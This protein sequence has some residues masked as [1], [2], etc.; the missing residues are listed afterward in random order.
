MNSVFI[1]CGAGFSGDR[2]DAASPVISSLGSVNGPRYLIYEVLAERTLAIA[3]KTRRSFPNKG[4]S[5]YLERYLAPILGEVMA[6]GIKIVTN[7][8]AANPLEA[9]R[10]VKK[11][12][13]DKNIE[14]LRIAIVNGDD[15]L[16]I[17]SEQYIRSQPII[18]GVRIGDEEIIAA[19]A[20]LGAAPIAEAL[21]LGVNIVL[22]GRTTDAALTLGPLIHE[23][24]WS[25]DD[26]DRLAQGTLAGHFLECGAQITGAYFADP[27]F[28]N[29]KGLE[30]VGFPI[31]E[32]SEIGDI[33]I[34]KANNTGGLVDRKT[35]IE[36][37]LYEIHD[38][39]NYLSA[40]VTLDLSRVSVEDV[41]KDR[42]LVSGAKGSSPPLTLKATISIDGGWISE[43]EITYAGPNSLARAEMAASIIRKR[44]QIIG[45]Q[46]IVRVDIFGT[47]SV[48]DNDNSKRRKK[49]NF[50]SYGEYRVRAAVRSGNRDICQ[51]VSDEVLSLYCS[52]PA[53]GGGV[54]QFID[55]QV[56][57]ASILVE[58]EEVM[59][60]VEVLEV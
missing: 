34:T 28:K 37:M 60:N 7:M 22:V 2:F 54:R 46:E 47:D 19:N 23:F 18:E 35:V 9:A 48:F 53:G 39:E 43:A 26:W 51:L 15:L 27:G 6:A 45:V 29:V 44:C 3:Q 24:G 20:Y 36:Q 25:Y 32:I 41:G 16:P 38:P 13:N 59:K 8:G 4:Y 17:Y 58:R 42:V 40:D 30:E 52:G 56:R 33:V 57:T 49:I 21:S 10:H 55:E 1:G 14:N 5:P 50:T 12:A 11:I 31:A